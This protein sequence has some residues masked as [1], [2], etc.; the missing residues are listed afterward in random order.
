[1]SRA[2]DRRYIT[3]IKLSGEWLYIKPGSI[4]NGVQFSPYEDTD[5][6]YSLAT[7]NNRDLI[8]FR[9]DAVEAYFVSTDLQPEEPNDS[10]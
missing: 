8:V 1:M 9:H 7:H 6:N 2:I 3:G 4:Q 5:W 10:N